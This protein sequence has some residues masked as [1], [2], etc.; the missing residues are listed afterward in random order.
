MSTDSARINVIQHTIFQML[1]RIKII[2]S[3]GIKQK[4]LD[5]HNTTSVD[6]K[7]CHTLDTENTTLV[8]L[9]KNEKRCVFWNQ[10]ETILQAL[11][12][13]N[14][15]YWTLKKHNFEYDSLLEDEKYIIQN[16]KY[17]YWRN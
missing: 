4:L 12:Q 13:T 8:G 2:V 9:L 16:R 15:P 6:R 3:S 14:L 7:Q 1:T 10:A 17:S 11:T 5:V